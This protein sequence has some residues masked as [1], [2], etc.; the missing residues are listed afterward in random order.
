MSDLLVYAAKMNP[1]TIPHVSP[2]H[3][4]LLWV[5]SVLWLHIDPKKESKKQ[6]IV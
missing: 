5:L 4:R 1:Q 2:Y 3:D 6:G